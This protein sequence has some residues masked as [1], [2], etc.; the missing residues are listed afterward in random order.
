LSRCS[1]RLNQPKRFYGYVFKNGIITKLKREAKVIE[2]IRILTI[3]IITLLLTVGL[4]GCS[5][6]NNVS[7]NEN[8]EKILG[9]WTATI[10]NTDII[11][12]MNFF[13]NGSFYE[14]IN[15]SVTV[16]WGT[17]TITG[18]TIAL[19]Y[20]GIIHT[21]EYSFSNNDDTLTLIEI[22]GGETYLVLMRQ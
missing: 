12:I 10:P 13:T 18:K 21:I 14:S 3:G 8:K 16:I 2:K 11:A 15:G 9:R 7:S 6:N 22:S 19:K 1:G 5:D 17:Y 4:S 20:G